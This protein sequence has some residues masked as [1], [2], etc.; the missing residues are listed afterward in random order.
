MYL[1]GGG[2]Y[3]VEDSGLLVA[4]GVQPVVDDL[5]LWSRLV[6]RGVIDDAPIIGQVMGARIDTVIAEADLEHLAAAPTFEAQRWAAPLVR[7]VLDRYR[8]EQHV[9]GLWIY[10]PR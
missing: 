6:E 3:L 4:R 1:S 9:G 7:V 2:R 8:L 10:A 5:F